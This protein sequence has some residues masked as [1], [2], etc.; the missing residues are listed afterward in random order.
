M[1][2]IFDGGRENGVGAHLCVRPLQTG[3]HAG[4]PHKMSALFVPAM[5]CF[6]NITPNFFF[7]GPVPSLWIPA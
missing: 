4:P 7:Q 2:E 1:S 5:N 3:G 6:N